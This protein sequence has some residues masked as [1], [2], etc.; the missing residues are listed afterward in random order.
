MPAMIDYT[1]IL[2]PEMWLTVIKLLAVS[3]P[4]FDST[5]KR[6]R[7][8]DA[9]LKSSP[10][11]WTVSALSRF[12]RQLAD[13]FRFQ[14]VHLMVHEFQEPLL[15][16]RRIKKLLDLLERRPEVKL[17]VRALFIGQASFSIE[18]QE[19]KKKYLAVEARVHKL[20]PDLQNLRSLFCGFMSFSSSLFGGVLK[21]PRLEKLEVQDFQLKQGQPDPTPNWDAMNRQGGSLRTLTVKAIVS[22]SPQTTSAVIRLLQQESLA[23]LAYWPHLFP[24]TRG[25]VSLFWIILQHIPDYVFTGLRRLTI[26]IPPSDIEVQRFVQ[27]GTQCPNVTSLTLSW[28]FVDSPSR[29]LDRLRGSGLA[30]HHFPALQHFKGPF[31]FAPSFTRGRPVDTVI[32]DPLTQHRRKHEGED[33]ATVAFNVAALKPSVPLR[34]LHLIVMEWNEADIEAVGQHHPGLEEFTYEYIGVDD[35]CWSPG[36]EEAF[37]KLAKLRMLTLENTE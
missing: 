11:I 7:N 5:T 10:Y 26:M 4:T 37:G 33:G 15:K 6:K 24:E 30:E 36:I 32:S 27:F 34:V 31:D 1:T 20:V 21:L 2:P 13:P 12:F 23:A 9:V 28:N 14:H 3:F 25:G 35:L 16:L 22:S 8:Q 29:L 17:W 18:H 19:V